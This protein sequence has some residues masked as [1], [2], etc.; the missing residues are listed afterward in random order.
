[1]T[2]FAIKGG[3]KLVFLWLLQQPFP[4]LQMKVQGTEP[5]HSLAQFSASFDMLHHKSSI[6]SDP[7][8][9]HDYINKWSESTIT[10]IQTAESIK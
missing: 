2:H 8:E 3:M 9:G 7:L 6:H 10:L 4:S 1:M 5:L